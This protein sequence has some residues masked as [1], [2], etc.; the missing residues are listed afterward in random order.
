VESLSSLPWNAQWSS[1]VANSKRRWGKTKDPADRCVVARSIVP[2]AH[3]ASILYVWST[4]N[5][6]PCSP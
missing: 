1:H 5:S 4:R 6:P 2:K 3:R